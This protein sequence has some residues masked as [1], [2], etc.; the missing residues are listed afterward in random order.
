MYREGE[1]FS[2]HQGLGM[3]VRRWVWLQKDR[4]SKSHGDGLCLHRGGS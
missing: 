1:Q 2:G 3:G 4:T